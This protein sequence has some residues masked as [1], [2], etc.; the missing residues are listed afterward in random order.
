MDVEQGVEIVKIIAPE[1]AIPI[2]YNDYDVFTSP[3]EDFEKRIKAAGL[4]NR[5]TYLK[6][7]ESYQF[8]SPAKP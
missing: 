6:H 2:H 1:H 5:V 4:E 7:G 3:I 8:R